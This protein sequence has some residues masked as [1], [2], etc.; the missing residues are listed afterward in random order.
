MYRLMRSQ[1]VTLEHAVPRLLPS[2]RH[3]Q[4]GHFQQFTA[5]LEACET[6]NDQGMSRYYVLNESS[7]EYYDGSW[8]D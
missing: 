4:V 8:I 2:Y 1:K 7:Q 5:A 3:T 6:A